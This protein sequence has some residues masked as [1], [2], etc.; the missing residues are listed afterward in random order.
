MKDKRKIVLGTKDVFPLKNNDI[1]LNVE[2]EKIGKTILDYVREAQE[3]AEELA[4]GR[5]RFRLRFD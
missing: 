2:K 3:E 5:E 4:E 1:F